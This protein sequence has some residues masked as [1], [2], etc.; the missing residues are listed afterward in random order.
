MQISASFF[1]KTICVHFYLTRSYF[2]E[3]SLCVLLTS[4]LR[5]ANV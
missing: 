3:M 4:K 5:D 2:R 1:Y